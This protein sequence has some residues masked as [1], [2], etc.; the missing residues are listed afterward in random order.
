MNKQESLAL[1]AQG[2]AAWNAWA[3]DMLIQRQALQ[4]TGTW[5]PGEDPGAWTDET[6]D[7]RAAATANFAGHEFDADADFNGCVFPGEAS[8]RDATFA[9]DAEFNGA[10]FAGRAGFDGARFAGDAGFG[11]ASFAGNAGFDDASFAGTAYFNGASFAGLA[12]FGHAS[13]AGQAGFNGASFTGNAWFDRA[14]FAGITGFNNA[15]FAGNARFLSVNFAGIA[16][17][18][19]A[20]FTGN[21]RFGGASFAGNAGFT[22]ASF[23]GDAGF[24][25]ASFARTARFDRATFELGAMFRAIKSERA[26]SIANVRFHHVPD[27]IQANFAAPPRLDD[28]R[29]EPRRF[30]SALRAAVGA[31]VGAGGSIPARWQALKRLVAETYDPELP[32]RWRALKKLAVEAHDHDRELAFFKGELQSRRWVVDLPW[33]PMF[34]FGLFYEWLSDY[35]RSVFRPIAWWAVVIALFAGL[36]VGETPTLAGAGQSGIAW[37]LGQLAPAHFATSPTPLACEAG[38]GAPLWA[39]VDLSVRNALI[40]AGAASSAKVNQNYACLYGIDTAPPPSV[41]DHATA[42][43]APSAMRLATALRVN[44]PYRVALYTVL[45]SVIS[46]VLLFLFLLAVRNHFRIK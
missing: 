16:G 15:S 33:R 26:F 46:A 12:A 23:A 21:A 2:K 31:L 4:D 27:F 28:C 42:G 10:S 7:W 35:G 44:I 32:A 34:W 6:R 36:Y 38:A 14:S 39:A 11:G 19:N 41:T 29:I 17:F 22:G 25:D 5:S 45:Q 9:G 30:R 1:Y 24:G 8:F 37:T 20:R 40:F 18:N 43:T 3:E 13:F